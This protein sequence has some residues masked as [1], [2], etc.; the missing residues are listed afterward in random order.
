MCHDSKYNRII[1]INHNL[2]A[3]QAKARELLKTE[4][5]IYHRKR[6]C[7]D[8]EPFL[9]KSNTIKTSKDLI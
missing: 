7:H 5:G 3:Y 4:E 9:P 1:T 2:L 8:V 6:R